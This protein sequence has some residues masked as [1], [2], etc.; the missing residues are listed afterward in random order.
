MSNELS[1]KLESNL[2]IKLRSLT[3]RELYDFSRRFMDVLNDKYSCFVYGGINGKDYADITPDKVQK[4]KINLYNEM[5][6]N[7]T[8][9]S[10]IL[11]QFPVTES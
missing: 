4:I 5:F 6:E 8:P 10:K 1:D 9:P 7:I 11:V 3:K 2:T